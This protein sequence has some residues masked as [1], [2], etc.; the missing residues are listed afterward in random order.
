MK[1]DKE[2]KYQNKYFS[3]KKGWIAMTYK[4]EEL[5]VND[6]RCIAYSCENPKYILIQPV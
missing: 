4:K 6:T 1:N 3:L 5:N 2:K